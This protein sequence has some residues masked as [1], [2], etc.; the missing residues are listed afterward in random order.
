MR[1]AFA[2]CAA[3]VALQAFA[4]P[5]P[6]KPVKCWGKAVRASGARVD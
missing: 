1:F 2:V 5:Y 6:F 3:V 4:Q